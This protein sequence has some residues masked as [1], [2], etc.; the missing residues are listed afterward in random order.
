MRSVII[1]TVIAV[2]MVTGSIL[3]TNNLDNVSAEL[4]KIN[5][6]IGESLKAEDFESANADI[7][8]MRDYLE[9]KRSVLDATG[10]HTEMDNIEMNIFEL[11]EYSKEGQKA[12]AL[13]KN[14][15]LGFLFEHLPMNYKLKWENI[16]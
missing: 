8:K 12:D 7:A 3:Y 10:N 4:I 14:R 2:V 13:S 6:Q 11:L 16:L 5:E 1:S 9:K 15:V